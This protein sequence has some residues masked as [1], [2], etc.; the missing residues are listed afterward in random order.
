MI[1]RVLNFSIHY[2][3]LIV[4]LTLGAAAY[5]LY[6]FQQLPIDAVPDVTNNQIQIN[7]LANG[8]SP[9]QV[10]KQVTYVIE[11][12]LSGIPGL[13]STRSLSR[14]G[15][16]QVT[17]IFQDK[18]NIYFARQQITERLTEIRESLPPG[19]DPQ[20]GPISTGL[21]EIYMYTVEF[22]HPEGKDYH[23][24][25]G[26][27]GWQSDGTY[28]TPEFQSLKNDFERAAYLRTVQDWIIRPQLKSVLGVAGVDSIGG[29]VV[30]YHV[31]PNPQ[32][33]IQFGITFP[34]IVEA[35]ENNNISAGAG[36]I[37]KNGEAFLVKSDSRINNMNEIGDVVVTSRNGMPIYLRDLATV[38][39]G[40]EMRTGSSSKNGYEVRYW[41]SHD[42]YRIQRAYCFTSCSS[43]ISRNK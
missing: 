5:G 3:Y 6:A 32:K 4:I 19:V 26:K 41:H 24:E 27:P 14:N 36:F 1:E 38:S 34:Q 18:V 20:M 31:Q 13:E 8:L 39:I 25:N 7:S 9:S 10:E 40:K 30:E 2:R 37:E 15:F 23:F 11:N 42:A 12:T 16:S 35:I 33:L 43:K 21:G 28:L 17:A 29:Y 22:L